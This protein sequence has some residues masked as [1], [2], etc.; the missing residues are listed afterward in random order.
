MPGVHFL[1]EGLSIKTI[2]SSAVQ[3]WFINQ[4]DKGSIPV[5]IVT[6]FLCNLQLKAHVETWSIFFFRA[7]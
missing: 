3:H 7:A 2:S 5:Y 1:N 4:E 6:F